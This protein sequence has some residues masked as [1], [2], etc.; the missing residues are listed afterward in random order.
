M[1]C[2]ADPETLLLTLPPVRCGMSFE[3]NLDNAQPDRRGGVLRLTGDIRRNVAYTTD[4]ECCGTRQR[5]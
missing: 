1:F 5:G 3:A 2:F 4:A